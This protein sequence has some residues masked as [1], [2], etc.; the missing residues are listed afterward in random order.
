MEKNMDHEMETGLLSR[1]CIRIYREVEK[2]NAN[3][4]SHRT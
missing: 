3:H 2:A 4:Y 1:D